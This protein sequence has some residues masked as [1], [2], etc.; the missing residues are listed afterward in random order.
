MVRVGNDG[1][2]CLKGTDP[3]LMK[4]D[5]IQR[6]AFLLL[7]AVGYQSMGFLVSCAAP[8]ISVQGETVPSPPENAVTS[9]KD[10]ILRLTYDV[11]FRLPP[12]A[13]VEEKGNLHEK[14]NRYRIRISETSGFALMTISSTNTE[15]RFRFPYEWSDKEIEKAKWKRYYYLPI[16]DKPNSATVSLISCGVD[17]LCA[18]WEWYYNGFLL[19]FESRAVVPESKWQT[20]KIA[21]NYHFL[22][23]KHLLVY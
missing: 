17:L 3:I 21:E 2:V 6:V 19:V 8:E 11:A 23:E 15:N 4:K 5:P 22:I 13:V 20:E 1:K 12:Q 7:L 14:G 10:T 16:S 18:R 9:G